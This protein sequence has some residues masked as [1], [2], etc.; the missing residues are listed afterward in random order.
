MAKDVSKYMHAFYWE[1]VLSFVCHL[2]GAIAE[3]TSVK[4]RSGIT[5]CFFVVFLFKATNGNLQRKLVDC[6]V[7]SPGY[8]KLTLWYLT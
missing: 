7:F 5:S 6:W 2:V 4:I 1:K 8:Q 3:G